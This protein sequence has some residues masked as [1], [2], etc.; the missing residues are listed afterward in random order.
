MAAEL[1]MN[2]RKKIETIQKEFTNKFNY[3]TLLFLDE[4]RKSLDISKSLSEVRK[5]KGADI[6]INAGLK[7]NTL[8][9][10]FMQHYGLLVE[11]AYMKEGKVMHTKDNVDKTLNEMNRWC[12]ENGCDKFTFKKSLKGDTVLSLQEQLFNAILEQYPDAVAKKINKDNFMDVHLPAVNPKKGTHI[13]FNTAKEGIKFGFYCRDEQF[14]NPILE[15]SSAIEAYAQGIRP[16]GNPLFANVDD[17]AEAALEFIREMMGLSN[18]DAD[19]TGLS[20]D[21]EMQRFLD[22]L[23]IDD[24]DNEEG[25]Q[26]ESADENETDDLENL[27]IKELPSKKSGTKLFEVNGKY[28]FTLGYDTKAYMNEDVIG[29]VPDDCFMEALNSGDGW[30]N[31]FWDN[32]WHEFDSKLHNHGIIEP[33]THLELPSGEKVEIK[34]NY[35]TPE[36]DKQKIA[37][38]NSS[39]K[40]VHIS[41]SAEKSYGWD[42]WKKYSV[43]FGPGVFD[44]SKILVSFDDDIVSGYTYDL[45]DTDTLDFTEDDA[46]ETSGIGFTSEL[47]FNN[48]K[49]LVLI[50]LDELSG[51]LEEKNISKNDIKSIKKYLMTK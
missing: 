51:E 28:T 11:V 17:A 7:V 39:G 5:V 3:L 36:F 15:R 9:A 16:K 41:S 30:S 37:F 26:T 20:A 34:L 40:F 38:N 45:S 13:F 21:E 44:T 4:N 19:E 47:Y 46:Y 2:G 42:G 22:N 24:S 29:I 50:D 43:N 31:Y 14:N 8:E 35:S 49:E 32:N 12:E 33:A 27:F 10:R 25:D 1:S 6:S 18:A 23:E 48:G